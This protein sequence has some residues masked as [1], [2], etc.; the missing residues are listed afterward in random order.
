[1]E[2]VQ[3]ADGSTTAIF[4]LILSDFYGKPYVLKLLQE[5]KLHPENVPEEL[6]FLKDRLETSVLDVCVERLQEPVIDDNGQIVPRA[7]FLASKPRC[8]L[9]LH[10]RRMKEVL[11]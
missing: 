4:V 3:L 2:R 1:M 6:L 9:P 11:R 10:F 5:R 8:E 7:L